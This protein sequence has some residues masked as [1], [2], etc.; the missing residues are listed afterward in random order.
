MKSKNNS[1]SC[2]KKIDNQQALNKDNNRSKQE[3]EITS[4]NNEVHKMENLLGC[5]TIFWNSELNPEKLN[6][7]YI[8]KEELKEQ[9]YVKERS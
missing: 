9:Q 3:Y 4:I 7:H 6:L 5:P 8:R 2:K 1:T